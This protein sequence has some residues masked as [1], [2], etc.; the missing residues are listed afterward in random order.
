MQF[1]QSA[2]DSVPVYAPSP[3]TWPQRVVT[4]PVFGIR[5][6]RWMRPPQSVASQEN[7]LMPV[8][9]AIVILVKPKN[10]FATSPSPTVNMWCAH[11]VTERKAIASP[12][13]TTTP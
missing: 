4:G 2:T 12:E 8:G 7:T 6:V 3:R 10:A 9:T 5:G 13:A 1:A 11:T